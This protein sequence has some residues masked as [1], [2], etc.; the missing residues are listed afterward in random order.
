[1][2]KKRILVVDD[3]KTILASL[4]QIIEVEGFIV[5]T[6]ETG[7]EALEKIWSRHYHLV[8]IDSRLPDIA[9]EKL[10][11]KIGKVWSHIRIIILEIEPLFPEKLLR[12][13][14]N[15]LGS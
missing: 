9:G 7:K 5:D 10:Q 3:D 11:E 6:V 2:Q 8:I 14:R 13:I 1:M 12:I 15:K 4:K